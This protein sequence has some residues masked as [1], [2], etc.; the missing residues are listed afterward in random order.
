M[1][2]FWLSK[3]S[4][5][6]CG[7]CSNIC[8]K[9]A[10]EM[11][12]DSM[13]FRYPA[14]SAACIDCNL[15]ENV[16]RRRVENATSRKPS[17]Y[18]AW[19]KEAEVRFSSTSG[20]AFTELAKYVIN[21][22][23][24]VYGAAYDSDN[25]IRHIGAT[26][27]Q[28]LVELRQSKYAQSDIGLVFREIRD[29]LLEHRKVLFCGTPCQAAGL[30]A[31]LGRDYDNL[32]IFDFICRGVN[33][34]KAFR[35][36]LSELES[37]KNSRVT[38]VWFKYKSGGWRKSPR[39]TRIDYANNEIDVFDQEANTYMVGYLGPNL[40][41]RPSCGNCDFKGVSR[42]SDITLADFWG[43]PSTLDDDGGTS[44]VMVNSEKGD[45]LFK[46]ARDQLITY[47][48]S[49]EEVTKGNV[50]FESSV[51]INRRST[52]FFKDLDRMSFSEALSKNSH[53]N[54]LQ[55]LQRATSSFFAVIDSKRNKV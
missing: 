40:Y 38:K 46:K 28:E 3:E 43:L 21:H 31:F 50:C 5:T 34:P 45:F 55:K 17:V 27:D 9:N 20:G 41:I 18:A 53:L 54:F 51:S 52:Q 8:P 1:K 11:M 26:S 44:L 12:Q 23:G 42:Y 29:Q 25:A 19:S 4:C 6:G 37:K 47:D 36:W 30:K 7:A 33:S 24:I 35:A 10:I 32:F 39:C 48:K 2:E 16:C 13:G 22:D 14:I 49:F 15:C